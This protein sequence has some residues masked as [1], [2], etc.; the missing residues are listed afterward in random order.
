MPRWLSQVQL[1]LAVHH[2][3]PGFGQD[4]RNLTRAG[5]ALHRENLVAVPSFEYLIAVGADHADLAGCDLAGQAGVDLCLRSAAVIAGNVAPVALDDGAG[6]GDLACLLFLELNVHIGSHCVP[7]CQTS[8][9]SSSLASA[10]VMMS[11]AW[12]VAVRLP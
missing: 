9:R 3:Q 10:V 5:G 7:S 8:S 1:G 4:Q 12:A 11:T 6:H 2:V